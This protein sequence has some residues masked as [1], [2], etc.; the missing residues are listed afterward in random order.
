MIYLLAGPDDFSIRQTVRDLLRAA[1]PEDTA[2]MNTTRLSA[3]DVTLDALRF[4]CEAMPFLADRR[5]V[6]VEHLFSTAKQAQVTKDVAAYLTKAPQNTLLVFVEPEAPPKSG[7]IAKALAEAQVKQ[8]FFPVLAGPPLQ[9]WI[10]ARAK[11][12]GATITD[13]AAEVLASF[14]GGDLRVLSHE[15]KK[16]ATYVGPGRTVDVPDV[17]LLVHQAHEAN[18]FDLVD[19]LGQ[20]NRSRALA[21]MHVLFEHGERPERILGMVARQVRLLLQAKDAVNRGDAPDAVGRLLGL[22]PFPTRKLLDQVR[23]FNL[24]QLLAMHRRVLETDLQIKTGRLLPALALELLV[25]ELASQASPP[26]RAV[27]RSQR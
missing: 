15:I 7:P 24:S 21:A 10:K 25:A 12:E 6:V 23:L 26:Q 4:A 16:L 3:G 8:Q 19:A 14:A 20:G 13:H 11:D 18:L 27:R 5:A 2:D 9:R 17:K 1:L 22:P